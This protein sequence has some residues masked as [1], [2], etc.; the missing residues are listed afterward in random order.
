MLQ[1]V[2]QPRPLIKK[3]SCIIFMISQIVQ[4][5]LKNC[6][7]Q[8]QI[9]WT[10]LSYLWK[11]QIQKKAVMFS[12]WNFY[13]VYSSL[14]IIFFVLQDFHDG[15]LGLNIFKKKHGASETESAVFFRTVHSCT[16]WTSHFLKGNRNTND[17]SQ[18]ICSAYLHFFY[19]W[20]VTSVTTCLNF[21]TW[22][23]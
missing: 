15:I 9:N 8:E 23:Y 6:N 3:K 19:F 12:Y 10:E 13:R 2:L 22:I 11:L 4:M 7:A 21:T 5:S 20:L 16:N 14:N 1:S 17:S 18:L